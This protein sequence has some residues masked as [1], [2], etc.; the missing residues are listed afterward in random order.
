MN[1]LIAS[2]PFSSFPSLMSEMSDLQQ[3]I[4]RLFQPTR[5]L[6]RESSNV[7][8]TDWI[9]AI[10]IKDEDNQY[11]IKADVPGVDPKDIEVSMEN[12]ALTI[13]GKKETSHEEKKENYFCMERSSGSFFRSFTLP[14]SVNASDIKAKNNNGVLIITVPKTQKAAAQKIKIES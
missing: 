1:R 3:E 2:R 7:M 13:K 6:G 8:V 9:P 10:D 12:G 11:V 14:Q 5:W 4:N